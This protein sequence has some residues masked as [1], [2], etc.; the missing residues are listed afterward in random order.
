[1]TRQEIPESLY[2]YVRQRLLLRLGYGQRQ[3]SLA[4]VQGG[5]HSRVFSLEI[6]GEQSLILKCISKRGRLRSIT[7]CSRFLSQKGVPVPDIIDVYEDNRFFNRRGIHILCET[8]ICG[9]T[10]NETESSP[11]LIKSIAH[12]F[13][14]MHAV[15][16]ETWGGIDREKSA[17]FFAYLH[18]KTEQR[19]A[20]WIAADPSV[21]VSLQEK[22]RATLAREK[23]LVD[24]MALFSLSHCDPNPGNI[25]LRSSDG[26]LFLLDPGTIRFMP[27]AI[28][29][30]KLCGFYCSN[31]TEWERLFEAAYMHGLSRQEREDFMA[32]HLFFK[33]YVC[34]MFMYD[35]STKFLTLSRDSPYYEEIVTNMQLVK[36]F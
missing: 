17:G 5:I 6:E 19:M 4:S 29:Y 14:R 23:D 28:E 35:L 15:T 7:R 34:T 16:R 27:R 2:A 18:E 13:S 24:H 20:T 30:Y 12:F 31:N 1:M 22:I 8:K 26:Q 36:R 25:I 32:T 9:E 21:S 33:L 3:F 11:D 10:L